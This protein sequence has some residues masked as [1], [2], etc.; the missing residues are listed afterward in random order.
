MIIKELVVGPFGSNCF[1]VGSETTKEAMI[2]D[3]G[4]DANHIVDAAND[5]GLSI[6]LIVA[7]HNHMD[8]IG[9]LRPV[10]DATNADYAVHEADLETKMPAVF[11]R[12]MG[13]LMG[14]SLKAPP[15]P[16]RL[17]HDGDIIEVGD[18]KFTVLHTPGHTP[19]GISL[20]GDGVVFSGDTLFNFGIGRTDMP[21][22][23][24]SILMHSIATK[25]M[26]LPDDTIVYPGHGPRTTIGIERKRNPFLA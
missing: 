16:D 8:H 6:V 9:A 2:I 13:P 10:K 19:G 1:I 15:K 14:G 4:A 21:G 7:T 12:M 25:L 22:G 18:L 11:A 26:V 17:L 3:P 24:F 5:L 23:S 20:L